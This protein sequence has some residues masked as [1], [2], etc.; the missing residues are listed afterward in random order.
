MSSDDLSDSGSEYVPGA[1]DEEVSGDSDVSYN[2]EEELLNENE[3]IVEEGWRFMADAFSDMR[4]E[5]LPVFS[6]ATG[7]SG[8]MAHFTCPC[9]AFSFSSFF[10][11]LIVK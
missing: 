10:F 4:L 1:S 9:D 3:S 5:S 2:R 8:H 7:I 6:N 11:F